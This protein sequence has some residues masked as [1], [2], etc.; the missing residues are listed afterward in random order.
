MSNQGG[1]PMTSMPV[2]GVARD[3][4][5]WKNMNAINASSKILNASNGIYGVITKNE[6]LKKDNKNTEFKL[7]INNKKNEKIINVKDNKVLQECT[8]NPF[9]AFLKPKNT[10]KEQDV[11]MFVGDNIGQEIVEEGKVQQKAEVKTEVKAEEKLEVKTVAQS[12]NKSGEIFQKRNKNTIQAR[13]KSVNTLKKPKVLKAAGANKE[14]GKIDINNDSI[15]QININDEFEIAN[16]EIDSLENAIGIAFEVN[17]NDLEAWKIIYT[18]FQGENG[19]EK[20][21][22]WLKCTISILRVGEFNEIILEKTI[23]GNKSSEI[24]IYLMKKSYFKDGSSKYTILKPKDRSKNGNYDKYLK[25]CEIINN[26]IQG[27]DIDEFDENT[28]RELRK[29]IT[30]RRNLIKEEEV[31]TELENE[32]HHI[33]VQ[34]N[35]ACLYNAIANCLKTGQ[36]LSFAPD[37]LRQICCDMLNYSPELFEIGTSTTDM[38]AYIEKL[39]DQNTYADFKSIYAFNKIFQTRIVVYELNQDTKRVN[40][41]YFDEYVK[42]DNTIF[43]KFLSYPSCPN[44]NHYDCLRRKTGE[45]IEILKYI[46]DRI[47]KRY[48]F[49]KIYAKGNTPVKFGIS[50][51][52]IHLFDRIESKNKGNG[53]MFEAICNSFGGMSV[54]VDETRRLFGNIVKDVHIDQHYQQLPNADQYR[55]NVL[56]DRGGNFELAVLA[57]WANCNIQLF[58]YH[59]GNNIPL[60]E[61]FYPTPKGTWWLFFLRFISGNDGHIV[62]LKPK[63]DEL[64]GDMKLFNEKA[65]EFNDL[66]VKTF[67]NYEEKD[68]SPS[69]ISV[70]NF[71]ADD[72]DVNVMEELLKEIKESTEEEFPKND[73]RRKIFPDVIGEA[74]LKAEWKFPDKVEKESRGTLNY[75]DYASELNIKTLVEFEVVAEKL[76]KGVVTEETLL[77]LE[78][79]IYFPNDVQQEEINSRY[80][81]EEKTSRNISP[82]ICIQ[83]SGYNEKKKKSFKIINSL[84]DLREHARKEH[85]SIINKG[86]IINISHQKLGKIVEAKQ[87]SVSTFWLIKGE[88]DQIEEKVETQVIKK[89]KSPVKKRSKSDEPKIVDKKNVKDKEKKNSF[90][91]IKDCIVVQKTKGKYE[92][93]EVTQKNKD[94]N[95]SKDMTLCDNIQHSDYKTLLELCKGRK[96]HNVFNDDELIKFR[97]KLPHN[98]LVD[99]SIFPDKFKHTCDIHDKTSFVIGPCIDI[100]CSGVNFKGEKVFRIFNSLFELK[101]HCSKDKHEIA[102]GSILLLDKPNGYEFYKLVN[103]N[104]NFFFMK[105]NGN[106]EGKVSG[107]PDGP[108]KNYKLKVY[109]HNIRSACTTVHKEM[110]NRF[111]AERKEETNPTILLL[112]ESGE[113]K[114][115]RLLQTALEN[116]YGIMTRGTDTAIIFDKRV[117]LNMIFDKLNDENNQ[118][119]V[120]KNNN[121]KLIIYN[122][123]ITPGPK[124]GM[125]LDAFKVR[126]NTIVSRY[127]D[128]KV[129]VFGDFNLTREEFKKNVIT[130]YQGVKGIKF[131]IDTSLNAF[132]RCAIVENKVQRSYLDYM[133]TVNMEDTDFNIKKPIGNSDHWL[134]E[135]GIA[136]DFGELNAAKELRYDFARAK[137]ESGEIKENLLRVLKMPNKVEALVSMVRQLR[138]RYKPR[139]KKV[140]KSVMF[141]EKITELLN[142]KETRNKKDFWGHLGKMIRKLSNEEYNNFM[143]DIEN[144]NMKRNLKEYFLKMRF[145]SEINKSSEIMKNLEI[146]H[147][148][149][150]IL[151]VMTEKSDIDD[152]VLIKYKAM[153]EDRNRKEHYPSDT[154]GVEF[155]AEEIAAAM[156]SVAFDKATSFDYIPGEV[157][158]LLYE[159][160]KTHPRVY[161][162]NCKNIAELLNQ[163]MNSEDPI[164]EEIMCARLLCLNK[165]PDENGKLDNIRPISITGMFVKLMEKVIQTRAEV[166]SLVDGINISKSQVGFVKGLGCDVNIMRLRQRTADV[167]KLKTKDEKYIFFID[168]KA[169]YDSVNHRKLFDKLLKKGYPPTL[170][171]H[172][173]KI[174]SSAKMRINLLQTPLNINKGVMQGGILSPWLFNIYIDDLVTEIKNN[175]FE[176]LAYADDIAVICKNPAELTNAMNIVQTWSDNNDIAINKKKSGILVVDQDKG[177][178]SE[179]NKYP[180]KITY[181]YL[182]IK[183]KNSLCPMTGLMD[184]NNKLDVYLKRNSWLMKQHFT[185]KSLVTLSMYYQYS[186][187]GYGM[188]CYLDRQ[189]I[190]EKVEGYSMK[191][192]KSILGLSNQTN[193]D[194]LRLILNRSKERHLLW[195]LLRKNLKKYRNHFQ[196]EAWIYNKV[197]LK[198]KLWLLSRNVVK[199]KK[200]EGII[201][202]EK[203]INSKEHWE[204]KAIVAQASKQFIASELGIKIGENYSMVHKKNYYMAPDKRDGHLI[205]YLVDFGFYKTRFVKICKHC[206][207]MNSRTHVTNSCRAFEDLRNWVKSK[208]FI[209]TEDVESAI[210]KAY[211][212]PVKD[213]VSKNLEILRSFAIKLIIKNAELEKAMKREIECK[214][215]D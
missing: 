21:A 209:S 17:K 70:I 159:E 152:K 121:K 73:I 25:R 64:Y 37:D 107:L 86:C 136:D 198:N 90:D 197:D 108:E 15:I 85:G 115:K 203:F 148:E 176:V 118:I 18:S 167:I 214:C 150:E 191:Y 141:R 65:K 6:S 155:K 183:V 2:I 189:D 212:E 153:F 137:E 7:I 35:G 113:V 201:E 93:L 190:I 77:E 142:D 181:K 82:C 92:F 88:E 98:V 31:K 39:R 40:K 10:P 131:H 134:L 199:L 14:Q 139:C 30:D 200:G 163:L 130:Y 94:K 133:I 169:A 4:A 68:P 119:C 187:I 28:R 41:M 84:H 129:I 140:A 56:T 89:K 114:K 168:L 117:R 101:K 180:V 172:I 164:P 124:H 36:F 95:D 13:S 29:L 160:S 175:C 154:P 213:L 81:I 57:K 165:C 193:S 51:S 63:K 149:E 103:G 106:K 16:E 171:S 116:N 12:G 144:L 43:L 185:P 91:W 5:S 196:E 143:C 179:I 215:D 205:R 204:L 71:A 132:T 194:R 48:L 182:G 186:R 211:Y 145:Y 80:L 210:L 59:K 109:G 127:K 53:C 166:I 44:N 128:A 55:K 99:M 147:K 83:C 162:E 1:T 47:N 23:T 11:E 38:K 188:S 173:K 96:E 177:G 24:F 9:Q 151:E 27:N 120:V 184:T 138:D 112:N 3:N 60:E 123:Y 122:T 170:I 111:L 126:F 161:M 192:T 100:K 207:Q 78:K 97:D 49:R 42:D 174:Y 178:K 45:N 72:N 19:F 66:L 67:S 32:F 62:A 26:Q 79:D 102:E 8:K 46:S 58:T 104:T 208:L 195:V 202:L 110:I 61:E 206:G 33:A 54:L 146:H 34:G 20:L 87:G 157:F 156:E 69:K 125:R 75:E 135:L 105:E 50:T 22:N 52:K 158:K 76:R 74:S